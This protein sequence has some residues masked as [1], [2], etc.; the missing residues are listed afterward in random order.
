MA[1]ELQKDTYTGEIKEVV[2][3]VG[4]KAKKVGG[5]KTWPL[6]TFE[7]EAPNPP[8][9]AMEVFDVPPEE[10][11]E[12]VLRPF[13]DVVNDPVAWA[14]KCVEE[15]GAEA[16]CLQ[17]VS[18]D[19]NGLNRPAEE[20]A[21]TAKKVV[22]AIDVPLIVYGSESPEKDIEVLR[23]VAEVC[24]GKNIAF[25]PVLEQ[26]YRQLGAGA[27]AYKHRAIAKT[28]IDINLA[29]QLNI[30]LDNLGVPEEQI[31]M[32]PTTGGLGYGIEY[33][34][35]V[36]ERIKLAA[37]KQGDDKLRLPMIN[38]MAV[39]V[40][41]TK[42]A[43]TSADEEPTWGDAEKRGIIMEAMTAL[44]LI[45]AGANILVMRHPKAIELVKDIISEFF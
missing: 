13:S 6:Y 17:L 30:L 3:G 23:K 10:W 40:W 2:I 38:N 28:S 15:Y 45:I 32:D 34:Y 37:L 1:F 24:D 22:E 43:K 12:A 20:A 9:I 21:E 18:T 8:L 33:T 44:Y 16:I 19:P 26:N 42:E 4:D 36:M 14:K 5:E 41:K 29:K 7:G 11:A 25:G 31:I 35:S 27:I 39:E